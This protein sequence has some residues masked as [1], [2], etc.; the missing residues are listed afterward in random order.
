[1]E[2]YKTIVLD[3]VRALKSV[4]WAGKIDDVCWE[5]CLFCKGVKD[6]S[7]CRVNGLWSGIC[8]RGTHGC[9]TFHENAGHLPG[10]EFVRLVALAE[11]ASE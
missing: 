5:C 9:H 1:M 10:C 6:G 8:A 7:T 4:E 11:A 2:T 3:V